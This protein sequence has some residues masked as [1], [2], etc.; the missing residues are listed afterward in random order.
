MQNVE[1]GHEFGVDPQPL[2]RFDSAHRREALAHL[3][4]QILDSGIDVGAIEGENAG[5]EGGDQIVERGGAVDR[6]M[7]A[8]ELPAAADDSRDRIARRKLERLDAGHAA[9]WGGKGVAVVSLRRKLLSP[10]RRMR[11]RL[12]QLGSGQATSLSLVI[13]SLACVGRCLAASRGMT[14]AIE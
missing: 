6:A 3:S 4:V 14:A 11:R 7:A 1:V 5:V 2:R 13:Q 8:G 12:G 10:R 9:L